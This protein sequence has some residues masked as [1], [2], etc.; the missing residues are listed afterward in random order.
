MKFPPNFKRTHCDYVFI[1]LVAVKGNQNL[2]GKRIKKHLSCLIAFRAKQTKLF[3]YVQKSTDDCYLL[4]V[5]NKESIFIPEQ[6]KTRLNHF[7]KITNGLKK[8]ICGVTSCTKY[9]LLLVFCFVV[10][11]FFRSPFLYV[12]LVIGPPGIM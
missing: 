10:A 11:V 12:L 3:L 5:D 8:R 4:P 2:L 7:L 6:R 1:T 9:E